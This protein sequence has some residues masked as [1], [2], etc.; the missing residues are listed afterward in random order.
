MTSDSTAAAMPL[1]AAA[2]VSSSHAPRMPTRPAVVPRRDV[3]GGDG[4]LG[5]G[6]KDDPAGPHHGDKAHEHD[7]A[8][9]DDLHEGEQAAVRPRPL[10]RG[11]CP[12]LDLGD[13][14]ADG[15]MITPFSA[16]YVASTRRWYS[17]AMSEK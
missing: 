12:G 6:A 2:S 10:D 15:A 14:V 11:E 5:E 16:R 4:Q 13:E 3:L 1:N 8:Q 9:D 7:Q 17:G